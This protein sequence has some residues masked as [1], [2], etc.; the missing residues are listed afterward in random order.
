METESKPPE[1][2][3]KKERL[4]FF[5]NLRGAIILLVIVF[6]V[7]IGFMTKPPQWWYVIDTQ[8]N[9]FFDLFVMATDV[10]IM[11]L[12]F[13]AAGY[14][15]LPSLLRK[16]GSVF[17]QNK[18][19]RIILP[20]ICGV[21]LFAAPITYMI[22]FSRMPVPPPYIQYWSNK[23][24]H[25]PDYNQA[26]YWFLGMLTWFYAFLTA[27]FYF[28]PRA[29]YPSKTPQAP[30]LKFLLGFGVLTGLGFFAG[31][32]FATA[33]AWVHDLYVF[34]FQPT[35]V[36]IYI[37]YFLLGVYGWRERWFTLKGYRPKLTLWLP[38]AAAMLLIF[39]GYRLSFTLLTPVP[40][41]FKLGHGLVHAFFCLTTCFALLAL[42]QSRF[43]SGEGLWRNL[44]KNS[45]VIYYI[46]QFVV[47]PLAYLVQKMELSV[48]LKYAG[49]SLG[50]VILCWGAANLIDKVI[51]ERFD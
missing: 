9:G 29:F 5:D 47:L 3:R 10:F 32:L 42:F 8:K 16:G 51:L 14:F 45:Y 4:Y 27:T 39:I 23:F 50:A 17:W 22:Y 6:H 25:L 36:L 44:G 12:L 26:H 18:G 30:G 49:V 2:G 34:S 40:V 11:P 28:K 43:N 38:A 7:A 15:T 33:D 48:W 37:A 20:W 21:L 41:L 24:F 31:N 19:L 35:R 13:F 1:R 46:H